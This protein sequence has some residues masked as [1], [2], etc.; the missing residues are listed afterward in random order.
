MDR[1]KLLFVYMKKINS[2]C[3][4]NGDQPSVSPLITKQKNA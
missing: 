1:R 4:E 2:I 3:K